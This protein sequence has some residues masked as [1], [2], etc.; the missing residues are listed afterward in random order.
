[1]SYKGFR[2]YLQMGL[3]RIFRLRKFRNRVSGLDFESPFF[4]RVMISQWLAGSCRGFGK[5]GPIRGHATVATCRPSGRGVTIL[6]VS[7]LTVFKPPSDFFK[8]PV[9]IG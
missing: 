2:F 3:C 9:D 5:L 7:E 4:K 1:M 6:L 8:R